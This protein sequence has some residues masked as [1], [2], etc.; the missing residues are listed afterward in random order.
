M[1]LGITK[2]DLF[3][4]HA[5]TSLGHCLGEY[6]LNEP[7]SVG[8]FTNAELLPTLLKYVIPVDSIRS[9]RA[10]QLDSSLKASTFASLMP[11]SSHPLALSISSSLAIISPTKIVSLFSTP[12]YWSTSWRHRLCPELQRR[13]KCFPAFNYGSAV[14]ESIRN[15]RGIVAKINSGESNHESHFQ[16]VLSSTVYYIDCATINCDTHDSCGICAILPPELTRYESVG[17]SSP[18]QRNQITRRSGCWVPREQHTA[19]KSSLHSWT[20]DSQWLL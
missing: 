16:R 19:P 15:L 7:N 4:A 20:F 17:S 8:I 18:F 2:D 3:N 1:D 9:L 13:Y 14:W 6:S 12:T 11:T 5:Q 10:I